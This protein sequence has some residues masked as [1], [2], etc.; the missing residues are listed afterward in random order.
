[1]STDAGTASSPSGLA[2]R[3]SSSITTMNAVEYSRPRMS[4]QVTSPTAT[5]CAPIGVASI[6]SY[7]WA[8]LSL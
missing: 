4:A 8:Y 3:P 6:A 1:M 2:T 7:V 5:S